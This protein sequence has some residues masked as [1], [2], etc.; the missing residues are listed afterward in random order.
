[1]RKLLHV[2]RLPAHI[3]V[4]CSGFDGELRY[5]D[6]SVTQATNPKVVECCEAIESLVFAKK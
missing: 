4:R 2:L 3:R 6:R 5:D 1:V